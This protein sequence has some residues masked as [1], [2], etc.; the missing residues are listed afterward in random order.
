MPFNIQG[1]KQS[2]ADYGYLHG[3]KFELLISSPPLLFSQLLNNQG[4]PN[5][6]QQLA[7]T[8]KFRI[9]TV[10]VPDLNLNVANIPRYGAGQPMEFPIAVQFGK[11]NFSVLLDEFGELWQYWYQ[12]LRLCFDGSGTDSAAVGVANQ[13]PSFDSNYKD[14]FSS[15]A[16]IIIYDMFGNAIQKINFYEAF[17][18]SIADTRLN[19]SETE[20]LLKLNVAMSYS[21]YTIVGS[22]LQPQAPP[23]QQR[24][25]GLA[26]SQ[27]GNRTT[28]S[29]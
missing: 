25:G 16:Q 7:R 26:S 15:V 24:T 14:D 19:W 23:P 27:L 10:S 5:D 21:Y 8:M 13:P 29:P 12:W 22:N 3:N 20:R 2:V 4:T 11:L 9:D 1:F 17:P 6:N 18:S 28:I